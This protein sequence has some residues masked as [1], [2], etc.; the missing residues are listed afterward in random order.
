M[1]KKFKKNAQVLV[2]GITGKEGE[3]VTSYML[4]AGTNVVAGVRPG[5]AGEVV[6]SVPV[7]DTIADALRK[8]PDIAISC[9][10]V[11]PAHVLK[12]SIEAIDSKIPLLHIIA[13]GVPVA[14][15]ARILEYADK[16]DSKILGPSSLGFYVP[17]IIKIGSLGGFDNSSFSKGNIGVISRSGGLSSEVSFILKSN[18]IGQSAVFHLGGDYLIGTTFADLI[19][20]FSD[21]ENTKALLIVGEVGGT[22]EN[23]FTKKL[24]S[25]KF[26]KPVIAYIGGQ[27]AETLPKMVPLGHAGAIIGSNKETRAGKLNALKKAGAVIAQRIEDIPSIINKL[28]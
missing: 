23:D 6:Q 19:K 14:D 2:Q 7:F 16:N 26:S 13:E 27:F 18:N 22:Y 24:I 28:K 9:V 5:K 25:S 17:N 11:P 3:L 4:S 12:A 15:T 1:K 10:Y 8:F 20:Y 21:D